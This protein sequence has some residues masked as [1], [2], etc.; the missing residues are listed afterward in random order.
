MDV[1]FD[2]T[3]LHPACSVSWR[4]STR[5][6]P[7]FDTGTDCGAVRLRVL[8]IRP[9]LSTANGRRITARGHGSALLFAALFD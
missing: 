8:R 3:P 2:S 4:E 1:D 5:D 9:L 6:D 7:N